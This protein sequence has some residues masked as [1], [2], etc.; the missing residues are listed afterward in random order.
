MNYKDIG[1]LGQNCIIG[2]LS[3]YGL[4][5]SVLLSDNQPFDFIA[6][7]GKKL[8]K[9]QVKT[10]TDN[11][12]GLSIGFSIQ[13]NNWLQGTVKK[14]TK[15]DCDII[16]CYDLVE[17]RTFLL[18]PEQFTDKGNFTIRYKK[19]KNN[20]TSN[21]N[22]YEDYELSNKRIKKVF[23][24]TPP[25]FSVYFSYKEENQYK[26]ICG[27]CKKEFIT[28][29]R[30]KKYCSFSCKRKMIQKVER[31]TKEELIKLIREKPMT[32][33][34][35]IFNVSDNAVR[36]WAISYGI[37]IKAIKSGIALDIFDV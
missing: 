19:A 11:R 6:I 3:K 30:N 25:D 17:H 12:D 37:N 34:G 27:Y 1:E 14:Y 29:N 26:M 23:D 9:I 13:T 7:A 28:N 20:N 21:I 22:W 24:F 35:K 10:S 36:K 8:F 5:I 15:D 32:H 16:A 33:I 31:P 4:G 18:T 2:E